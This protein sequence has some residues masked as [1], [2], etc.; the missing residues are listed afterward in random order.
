MNIQLEAQAVETIKQLRQQADS[1]A[2]AKLLHKHRRF[3]CNVNH[4]SQLYSTV[5]VFKLDRKSQ[6]DRKIASRAGVITAY[7]SMQLYRQS[8]EEQKQRLKGKKLA[9]DFVR[10]IYEASVAFNSRTSIS[11]VQTI[12]SSWSARADDVLLMLG[13]DMMTQQ[14][15]LLA[16]ELDNMEFATRVVATID[17]Q[18]SYLCQKTLTLRKIKFSAQSRI[19]LHNFF[20]APFLKISP[21]DR[22]MREIFPHLYEHH[23]GFGLLERYLQIHPEEHTRVPIGSVMQTVLSGPQREHIH[24]NVNNS[25]MHTMCKDAK[26]PFHQLALLKIMAHRIQLEYEINWLKTYYVSPYRYWMRAQ[27]KLFS[28][29]TEDLRPVYPVG[30]HLFGMWCVGMENKWC[31]LM[32]DVQDMMLAWMACVMTRHDGMTEQRKNISKLIQ[33]IVSQQDLQMVNGLL[34]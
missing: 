1:L 28:Q 23:I 30:V 12:I 9:E 22:I 2:D 10:D 17:S 34:Q 26:H 15:L 7:V 16:P 31:F 27:K 6:S 21:D 20:F 18:V 19:N 33:G 24:D 11:S 4:F 29:R 8:T 32:E 3:V 25:H 5:P 14:Q 13:R